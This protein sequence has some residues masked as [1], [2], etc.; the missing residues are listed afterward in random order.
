MHPT[1][2]AVGDE[3]AYLRFKSVRNNGFWVDTGDFLRL[4][5]YSQ[6]SPLTVTAS[7]RILT[8]AGVTV[9]FL[10]NTVVSAAGSQAVQSFPATQ[11]W[12][13]T[14]II[15]ITTGTA[16]P[17]D[18]LARLEVAQSPIAALAP[19]GVIITGNPDSFLPAVYTADG[20]RVVNPRS[21]RVRVVTISNPAAGAEWATTVPAGV[22][23]Q[24][25]DTAY[26]LTT[27]ATVANRFSGLKTTDGATITADTISNLAQAASVNAQYTFAPSSPVVTLAS[28]PSMWL[29]FPF[30]LLSLLAGHTVGTHTVALQAGDQYS[31]IRLSVLE[32]VVGF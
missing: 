9:P 5:V 21:P 1:D 16:Q 10:I 13:E 26:F 19:L 2:L 23:W 28:L 15:S 27:N 20:S 6:A 25:L 8:T 14:A 29:T 31:A 22:Q 24:L 7:G 32:T 12:I 18:V 4:A 30:P 3:I 17:G 11:G